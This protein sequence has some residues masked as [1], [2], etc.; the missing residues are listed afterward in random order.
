MERGGTASFA[1]GD[2]ICVNK[3]DLK[4]LKGTI[5]S[6]DDSQIT[7]KAFGA[8]NLIPHPLTVDVSMVSKYFEPGD[9]V[10]VIEAKYKGETG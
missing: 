6:I 3:G 7:F 4:D 10:R 8:E 2:K 9:Q 1:K 5:D